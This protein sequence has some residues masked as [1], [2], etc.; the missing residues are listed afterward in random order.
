MGRTLLSDALDLG[1]EV[2]VA[3]A[4]GVE[5]ARVGRTLLSDVLDFA[6]AIRLA[7]LPP[8]KLDA[9]LILAS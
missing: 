1:V 4:I 2:G 6:V 3:L 5:V 8:R 7:A 9:L